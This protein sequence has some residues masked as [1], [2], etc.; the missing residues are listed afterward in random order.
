MEASLFLSELYYYKVA[1]V[2]DDSSIH[3]KKLNNNKKLKKKKKK[4][5]LKIKNLKLNKKTATN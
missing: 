5:K 1:R 4:K 3:K 2:C